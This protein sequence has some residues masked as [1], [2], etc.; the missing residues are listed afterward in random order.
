MNREIMAAFLTAQLDFILFFYGLAFILLGA[1][2]V[3]IA[4]MSGRA[5]NWTVLALF[6]FLHGGSEWL[7]LTALI[8][9]D[10]PEFAVART[11]LM[12]ASFVLLMEFARLE[13]IRFGIKAPGRW[14]YVPLL[15]LVVIGGAVGGVNAAG[16]IA[17]YAIAFTGALATGAI[18]ARFAY[19]FPGQTRVLAIGAA[20]GFALYAVAAGAIVPAS[21][22]WPATV[23][24]HDWFVRATGIPIQLVRGMLACWI[25]FSIWAI[26]GERLISEI[27][28][29]RYT[30][31]MRRQFVW[32]LV[33]MGTI[34]VVGWIL[35]E[36]LGGIYKQNVQQ[37]ARGNIDLLASRLAG[38]TATVEG[39]VKALAG[40][41]SVLPLLVGENKQDIERAKSVLDLDVDASGAE[42]GYILNKSGK[43]SLRPTA[44]KVRGRAS[45]TTPPPRIS[46]S[47]PPERPVIRLRSIRRM[48]SEITMRATRSAPA[49]ARFSVWRSSRSRL[50]LWK[51]ISADSVIPISSSILM[52]LSC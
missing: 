43:S 3:A 27:S 37:M 41:P 47:R 52:A 13:A 33:A 8:I 50:M 17:R 4:R 21:S 19:G 26:W 46:R 42:V 7:D 12:T 44:G 24:N 39:M 49:V 25:A 2:C 14:I 18:F 23:I 34:L 10:T 36:Y 30:R 51:P 45:R 38:E 40:S 20:I 32:T 15:S 31:F 35:T 1:T 9:G 28:S 22:I 11:V 6:G 5:E 16:S 48:A 29:A